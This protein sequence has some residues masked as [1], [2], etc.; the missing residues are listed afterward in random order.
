LH[1]AGAETAVQLVAEKGWG[2][3]E[4]G[5]SV[6]LTDEGRKLIK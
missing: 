4:G 1:L 6:C 3:I 2:L 5:H